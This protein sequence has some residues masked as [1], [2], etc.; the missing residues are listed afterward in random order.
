MVYRHWRRETRGSLEPTELVSSR[1]N[2]Y[3]EFLS[4][5]IRWMGQGDA[6]LNKGAVP[7]PDD[8]SSLPR[9]HRE[10]GEGRLL[11]VAL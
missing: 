7:K 1:F 9:T 11:K 10:E 3:G 2:I 8:L 5:N 4:Q 6:S